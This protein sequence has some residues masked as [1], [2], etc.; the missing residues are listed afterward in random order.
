M[1]LS[2]L[3]SFVC[4]VIVKYTEFN[5]LVTVELNQYARPRE[6]KLVRLI[7]LYLI[8]DFI[9]IETHNNIQ[10]WLKIL[11]LLS[12]LIYFHKL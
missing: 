8:T 3:I 5:S 2:K 6:L 1:L 7:R 4:N 10:I 9:F 12:L 11:Y